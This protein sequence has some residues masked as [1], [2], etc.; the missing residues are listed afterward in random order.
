MKRDRAVAGDFFRRIANNFPGSDVPGHPVVLDLT[1]FI[2]GCRCAVI[3]DILLGVA[4]ACRFRWKRRGRIGNFSLGCYFPKPFL[5][6]G[7]WRCQGAGYG[8]D[9]DYR[10]V[11]FHKGFLPFSRSS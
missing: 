7:W 9:S 4:S 6:L 2:L 5:H 10:E 3:F 1:F 11:S 8:T